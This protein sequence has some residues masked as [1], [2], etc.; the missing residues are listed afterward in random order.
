MSDDN[1]LG[2]PDLENSDQSL[3][4]DLGALAADPDS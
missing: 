4:M 2:L 1:K 3:P